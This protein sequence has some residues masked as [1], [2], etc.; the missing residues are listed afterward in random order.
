MIGQSCV[1][2]CRTYRDELG[3]R[4]VRR[5]TPSD[6]R[7]HHQY[8]YLNMWTP[9]SRQVLVASN[10]GDGIYRHYLVDVSTG[11]ATCLTD[12]TNLSSHFGEL[13]HD[14]KA[15]VYSAGP[16][17]RRRCLGDMTEVTLYRQEEPWTGRSVYYSATADHARFV[18]VEM[19]KDDI[20][21]A[22]QGWDA[23]DR[24]WEVKPRCR[25]VELDGRSGRATII[26]EDRCWIGHPNYRPDG[27][28]VMFCHEGPWQRVDS[29]IW[30]CQ[31][32]GSSVR[33]ARQRAADQP[34]G[35][36]SGELWGHE[37]WLADSSRAGFIHFPHR[38]GI[39]A[40]LRF[41][42]PHTL[43]EEVLMPVGAYSHFISNRDNTLIIGDGHGALADAIYLVDTRARTQKVFCRHGSSCK[44]YINPRT[45]QPN[46][47]EVHPHPCF[48][49]DS[50]KVVFSSDKD[51]TPAVY[52]AEV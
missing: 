15:L 4:T 3:G 46:T 28:T 18:M 42:E 16:E 36:G 2:E 23:F 52:V 29:R 11:E 49:P 1:F 35:E 26:H 21:E 43:A 27:R 40:T 33:Q 50:A 39:D 25:L 5:I 19:H 41:V 44:P 10:R 24:Q 9:D 20:V 51:G 6:C 22:R 12:V 34:A 37:Y 48:S 8:F 7:S 38:Y 32:D 13:T 17:L 14:G 31:P 30:F 47:Q 45:G